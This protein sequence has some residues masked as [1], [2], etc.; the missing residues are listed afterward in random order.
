MKLSA[1]Q[2][3]KLL[4]NAYKVYTGYASLDFFKTRLFNTEEGPLTLLQIC[5]DA[6]KSKQL[7]KTLFLMVKFMNLS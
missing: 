4:E 6:I 7:K 3:K 1:L 2:K 5:D